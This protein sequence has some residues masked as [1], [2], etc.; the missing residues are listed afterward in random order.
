MNKVFIG[1]SCAF[2]LIFE[3]LA[4]SKLISEF[5]YGPYRFGDQIGTNDV[6]YHATEHWASTRYEP[7]YGSRSTKDEY[8]FSIAMR[9]YRKDGRGLFSIDLGPGTLAGSAPSDNYDTAFKKFTE[10]IAKI[11]HDLG[12]TMPQPKIMV[13]K[14]EYDATMEQYRAK[15]AAENAKGRHVSYEWTVFV[16]PDF[17]YKGTRIGIRSTAWTDC[18]TTIHMNMRRDDGKASPA[19]EASRQDASAADSCKSKPRKPLQIA[20]VREGRTYINERGSHG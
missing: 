3:C 17:D 16:V 1:A 18:P 2:L 11:E 8:G 19:T 14:D 4:D 6:S 12:I 5:G 7:I 10:F 9:C 20:E 15:E 13:P